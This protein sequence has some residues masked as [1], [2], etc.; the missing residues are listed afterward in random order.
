MYTYL[1]SLKNV[2]N[3][4][5]NQYYIM[6]PILKVIT[7][8]NSLCTYLIP[9]SN[10]IFCQ[11]YSNIVYYEGT[12]IIRLTS[13]QLET[14]YSMIQYFIIS[15]SMKRSPLPIVVSL[16]Q[17]VMQRDERI[18]PLQYRFYYKGIYSRYI[19]LYFPGWF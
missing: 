3:Q 15:W 10:I 12:H 8:Q 7:V 18:S 4:I 14:H 6:I 19:V 13:L 2:K 11:F 9:I 16:I 5:L 1:P 17:F